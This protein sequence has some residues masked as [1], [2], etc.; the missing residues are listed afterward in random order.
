M[1]RI[2][3]LTTLSKLP[4]HLIHLIFKFNI[5]FFFLSNGGSLCYHPNTVHAV[6]FWGGCLKAELRLNFPGQG[7]M[8]P[9]PA[10]E[11]EQLLKTSLI[12][13][14]CLSTAGNNHLFLAST[15]VYS[16][17]IKVYQYISN[18]HVQL[19]L[20]RKFHSYFRIVCTHLKVFPQ[21]TPSQN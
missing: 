11:R 6:D 8:A 14:T 7:F 13:A 19:L 4:R 1:L 5:S 12:R 2:L 21:L 3:Q 17:E 9:I 10:A 20:S 16:K 18:T 15:T